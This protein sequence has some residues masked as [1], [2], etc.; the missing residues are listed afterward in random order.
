MLPKFPEF[1]KI[2]LNDKQ[3]IEAYTAKCKPY[4]DF[5]F[6]NLWSWNTLGGRMVSELN[7][8]LVILF[9]DYRT[10]EP[11]LSFLG[12]NEVEDTTRQLINFSE[13]LDITPVLQFVSEEIANELM[14]TGL[15]VEEDE[16]NFDY[17]FSVE[18]LAN[19]NGSR[20]KSKR[21]LS[22]RFLRDY[23]EASMHLMDFNDIDTQHQIIQLMRQWEQNK[24]NQSKSCNLEHEEIALKRLLNT[25]A[26]HKL[27][28]SCVYID[29]KMIGFSIDEILPNSYAISHFIKG[30]NAYKGVYEFMN[31]YVAHNLLNHEV[32][33]WN[34]EQDLNIEGLRQLKLSYRPVD[35]L[36][37]Y[38]VSFEKVEKPLP[39]SKV[40]TFIQN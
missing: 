11:M 40:S 39:Q 6:T 19:Q 27:I 23:P 4:S 3:A 2:D 31:E 36:K 25:S 20:F 21:H 15:V 7:D 8:N 29:N 9:T 28:L 30:D 38:K 10:N 14:G 37:K 35:F 24:I 1:K 13:T 18:E 32:K 26:K 34:W 17:I 12:T 5:N 33:L 22:K 16:H